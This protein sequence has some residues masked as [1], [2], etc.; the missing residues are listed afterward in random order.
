MQLPL[1]VYR[2]GVML[3]VCLEQSQR[4]LQVKIV[5]SVRYVKV[6]FWLILSYVVV[7]V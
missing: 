2:S 6:R 3:S 5:K 7:I 4:N 1:V